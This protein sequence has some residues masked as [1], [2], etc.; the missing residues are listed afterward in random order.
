MT[1]QKSPV[2]AIADTIAVVDKTL[3]NIEPGTTAG[4][5]VWSADE[6]RDMLGDLRT[7][8]AVATPVQGGATEEQIEALRET[9]EDLRRGDQIGYSQYV[10]LMT[11]LDALSVSA[12]A[13]PADER[14]D[15]EEREAE[16][17]DHAATAA[18]EDPVAAAQKA[19]WGEVHG[20]DPRRKCSVA[21]AKRLVYRLDNAIADALV[22]ADAIAAP[23]EMDREKLADFIDTKLDGDHFP[24][25]PKFLADSILDEFPA[26]AAP[27]EI[28]DHAATA[29]GGAHA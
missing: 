3:D 24:G 7:R 22:I 27:V 12:S 11:R 21:E 28:E 8:L 5:C 20:Q 1:N 26:L 10:Y 17:E 29:A 13:D 18:A 6:V 9:F 25:V 23:V 14:H 19:V 4:G 15:A 16:P 2:Q